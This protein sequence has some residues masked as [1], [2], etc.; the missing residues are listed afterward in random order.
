MIW[1]QKQKAIRT[2]LHF[3]GGTKEINP[4][5]ALFFF[6]S[7]SCFKETRCKVSEK[8]AAL[9]T[10]KKDF[11]RLKD[12]SL[13]QVNWSQLWRVFLVKN[14]HPLEQSLPWLHPRKLGWMYPRI[15]KY[16][17]GDTFQKP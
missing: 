1:Q 7:A 2:T 4:R 5:R 8:E 15:A 12:E 16:W 6:K 9:E 11:Q 10:L 17:K 14:V 3:W 13:R